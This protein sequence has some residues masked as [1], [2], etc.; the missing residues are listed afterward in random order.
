MFPQVEAA[1]DRKYLKQ[2]RKEME[3]EWSKELSDKVRSLAKTV[4]GKKIK[5]KVDELFSKH[6]LPETEWP[7]RIGGVID[8]LDGDQDYIFLR[9]IQGVGNQTLCDYLFELV[10]AYYQEK[11]Y[12]LN[13]SDEWF[14]YLYHWACMLDQVEF[15]NRP[16]VKAIDPNLMTALSVR[17][18]ADLPLL[19][20][21]SIHITAQVGALKGLAYLIKQGAALDAEAMGCDTA[22]TFAANAKQLAAIKLLNSAG[23]KLISPSREKTL[24]KHYKKEDP[25]PLMIAAK[26]EFPELA[27]W[28]L[29]EHR[30]EFTDEMIL[31]AATHAIFKGNLDTLK[32]IY[33]YISKDYS[34][35]EVIQCF[36]LH[37]NR[38]KSIECLRFVLE[39]GADPNVIMVPGGSDFGP[40]LHCCIKRNQREL[41]ELLLKAHANPNLEMERACA[42]LDLLLNDPKYSSSCDLREDDRLEMVKLLVVHGADITTRNVHSHKT[43]AEKARANGFPAIAEYLENEVRLNQRPA[44]RV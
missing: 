37:S 21:R 41:V 1:R 38:A 11:N 12:D 5:E 35:K 43:P 14:H 18:W 40:L 9:Y 33:P 28:C 34:N 10:Q 29:E 16:E 15:L 30:A 22:I 42:P 39:Q 25:S 31:R 20:I 36:G 19:E 8:F 24:K 44:F 13:K 4:D 3:S 17:N 23:A 32:I 27:K 2:L 6:F 7:Y 26:N